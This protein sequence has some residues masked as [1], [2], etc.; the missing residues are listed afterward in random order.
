MNLNIFYFFVCLFLMSCDKKDN[1]EQPPVTQI[2]YQEGLTTNYI[3]V[4]N[5]TRKYLVYRPT[6]ITTV[7][8]VVI[9]LHG[10]GGL[11][12]DVA[13]PGVHPLSVFR[14]IADNEK[15][16]VVYPEG[17][18]DIQGSPGW[19]DCRSDDKSGSQGNDITF[20]KQLNQKLTS[21]LNVTSSK[22]FLTGTSNGAL[23]TYSYAF[24]FPETVRAIAVSSGNLPQFPESGICT[25]GSTLPIP[26][27]LTHGT[28]DPA[29]PA[30]GGCVA[31]LGGACNRGKV[32]SQ[33]ET[34]NYWLQRNNLQNVSP[35][36]TTFDVNTSDAGNVE[37]RVYN[38]TNPIVYFVLKNAGHS[39][40]SKTIY[41]SSSTANGVQN[42]DIEYADE[43][44]NFFKSLK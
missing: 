7:N 16:I 5:I 30:E 35:I 43:V 44:W 21:D 41:L 27:L 13:E 18:L 8:A 19:N 4:K 24:Q 40:A 32:I 23:M 25:N 1:S 33:T 12:L 14:T 38:G 42:R 3:T 39:V 15:F 2:P 36:V 9:V 20:L 28:S 31:N 37:K 34:I 10:G 17:S 29:M 6:G 11:G 22:I 26:I